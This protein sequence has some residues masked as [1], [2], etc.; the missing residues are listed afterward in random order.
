[1]TSNSSLSQLTDSIAIDMA[2]H[3]STSLTVAATATCSSKNIKLKRQIGVVVQP[4]PMCRPFRDLV[5]GTD[6][7]IKAMI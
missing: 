2:F 6:D 1:M 5:P 4:K 7:P 3:S